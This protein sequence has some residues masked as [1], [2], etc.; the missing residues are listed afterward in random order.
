MLHPLLR[1]LPL[2][3]ALCAAGAAQAKNLVVCTEA[4]RKASTSSSTPGG[5]RRRLPRETVFNRLL[6]FRPG[7]TEVI[8]GL[9]E[10]WDVSA[11][12]TELYLHLRPGV[13][14]YRASRHG[15]TRPG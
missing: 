14:L 6:A 2:A 1:H 9:A 15:R 7:T 12:R 4:S 3:L 11:G 10:R 5:D 13:G 8:P